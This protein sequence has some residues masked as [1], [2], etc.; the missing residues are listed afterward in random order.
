[1]KSFSCAISINIQKNIQENLHSIG[2]FIFINTSL[3]K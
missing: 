2:K 1:M 3:E